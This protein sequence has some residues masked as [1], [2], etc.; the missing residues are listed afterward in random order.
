MKREGMRG[1]RETDGMESYMVR[2]SGYGILEEWDF[3][4]S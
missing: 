4:S 3:L 2:V 1:N